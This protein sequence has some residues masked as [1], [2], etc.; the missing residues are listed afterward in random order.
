MSLQDGGNLNFR[1]F[2]WWTVTVS[3]F[4]LHCWR[5]VFFCDPIGLPWQDRMPNRCKSGGNI[6]QM[7]LSSRRIPSI[8]RNLMEVKKVLN[9]YFS[10][11]LDLGKILGI[12]LLLSYSFVDM[13][14]YSMVRRI[15][16]TWSASRKSPAI[17]N[18]Y[19]CWT[20]VSS[21]NLLFIW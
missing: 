1:K 9:I 6:N 3:I 2:S 14:L 13:V 21:S 8:N 5:K 12:T 19:M 17:I 20:M 11:P 18:C 4:D 16:N 15:Q 7:A 10:K